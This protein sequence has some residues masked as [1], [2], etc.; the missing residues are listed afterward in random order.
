MRLLFLLTSS[1]FKHFIPLIY[2]YMYTPTC[3]FSFLHL[4]FY[5]RN[6]KYY[7]CAF[8]FFLFH[9]CTN[10]LS[11]LHIFVH[12]C[13]FCAPLHVRAS[14]AYS[15]HLFVKHVSYGR[16]YTVYEG[17]CKAIGLIW[18]HLHLIQCSWSREV[19]KMRFYS[20]SPEKMCSQAI[21]SPFWCFLLAYF[22][23]V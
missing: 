22:K 7:T 10:R 3:F 14:P 21:N 11:S 23:T 9:P 16:L 8:Y 19:S 5:S 13:T 1:L 2:M 20:S 4:T 12:H 18:C 15:V 17:I 6:S